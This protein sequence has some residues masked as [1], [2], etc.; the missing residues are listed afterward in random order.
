MSYQ[1]VYKS[2]T[3]YQVSGSLNFFHVSGKNGYL[4]TFS[5]WAGPVT[6]KSFNYGFLSVSFG[7]SI[8]YTS[9][10]VGGGPGVPGVM[11][12]INHGFTTLGTLTYDGP[13]QDLGPITNWYNNGGFNQ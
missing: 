2:F 4:P 1:T 5:D 6:E 8:N 10:S 7:N 9:W 11:G 13:V 12:S 3:V